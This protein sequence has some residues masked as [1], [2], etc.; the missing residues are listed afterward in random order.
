MS[1]LDTDAFGRVVQL[2]LCRHGWQGQN[3]VMT[4]LSETCLYGQRRKMMI[5]Q[6]L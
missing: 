6:Q 4:I 1:P 3:L 5:R 2:S